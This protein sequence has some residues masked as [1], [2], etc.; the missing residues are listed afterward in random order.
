MLRYLTLGQRRFGL[1]PIPVHERVNWEFYAVLKGQVGSATKTT[2]RPALF[3]RRLWVFPP[4][5]AHGWIGRKEKA[6]TVAGFHFGMVPRPLAVLIRNKGHLE[7][8]LTEEQAQ[9][10]RQIVSDLTPHFL[11]PSGISI[12]H[13]EKALLD[14]TL[15]ALAREKIESN[16]QNGAHGAIKVEAALSWYREHL[17]EQ[18]KLHRV[19]AIVGMSASHLRRLFWKW[20][21]QTPHEAFIELKMQHAMKQLSQSD[22][23]LDAVSIGS[24]FTSSVDFCRAFKSYFGISPAKWRKTLP[25]P[26]DEKVFWSRRKKLSRQKAARESLP[27]PETGSPALSPLL[28]IDFVNESEAKGNGHSQPIKR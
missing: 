5:M 18:P 7:I 26:Y 8:A 15:M 16:A 25:G 22:L 13:Y 3:S 21:K 17:Q 12:L 11:S 2:P 19:A 28:D 14:L 4:E 10:I 27:V 20:R 6:A 1:Y 23:K 9:Q 24:G